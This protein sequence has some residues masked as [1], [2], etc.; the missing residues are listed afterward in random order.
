MTV[1]NNVH[2]ETT[3]C[4]LTCAHGD[5]TIFSGSDLLHN[6]PGTF[7]IV[8][9]KGCGLM[10]TNPRP[11]PDS[12]GYYYPDNYGPYLGTKVDRHIEPV[13]QTL[14]A[15]L[16]RLLQR[17]TNSKS[18]KIPNIPPGKMLEI[19]CASGAF[20]DQMAQK[21][22]QVQGVEFSEK[23]GT[24]AI[25]LGYRVHIGSLESMPDPE[26]KFDLITGWMV[27]E[28]LHDP[29]LGL[30]KLR[31]AASDHAWLAISVPN[32]ASVEFKIFK[33][34]WYALHLPNHLF[35]FTPRT[36]NRV[37]DASGWQLE[38]IHHQVNIANLIAS[39]GYRLEAAGFK[40]AGQRL[41]NFP[42]KAGRW[43]Y[44]LFPIAW[45]LSLFGQTGRMTVW[46]KVKQP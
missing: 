44:V 6:L 11:T 42:D 34:N 30:K 23:A 22:W 45:T 9:C 19:G 46:A 17:L 35:H 39:L 36:I 4:P 37:L 2:L 26:Q 3:N 12:I 33:N 14:R 25:E 21:G 15:K 20:L 5:K 10:R 24:R 7:T 8:Q 28:H 41:I 13:S 16:G 18:N 43:N 29:I 27:L 31:Q 40:S 38:K 1:P 32:C